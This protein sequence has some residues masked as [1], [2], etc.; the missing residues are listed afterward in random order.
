MKI[1]T[2]ILGIAIT[3]AIV[4]A[5]IATGAKCPYDDQVVYEGYCINPDSLLDAKQDYMASNGVIME[6][7]PNWDCL[8]MGNFICGKETQRNTPKSGK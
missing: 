3:V 1:Q 6:D 4:I 5:I 8:T 2:I 7:D